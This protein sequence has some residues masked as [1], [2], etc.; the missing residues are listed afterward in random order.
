LISIRYTGNDNAA[1]VAAGVALGGKWSRLSSAGLRGGLSGE[2]Q[3]FQR[4]ST[5]RQEKSPRGR[6]IILDIQTDDGPS[7]SE[8]LRIEED[9]AASDGK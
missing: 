6:V 1:V 7:D 8:K 3:K 9:P 2:A 4:K 5:E